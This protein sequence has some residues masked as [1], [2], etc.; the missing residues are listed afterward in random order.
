MR[1]HGSSGCVL[2]GAFAKQHCARPAL[3]FTNS[4]SLALQEVL[5]VLQQLQHE[6]KPLQVDGTR[7]H[8]R[9]IATVSTATTQSRLHF[10]ASLISTGVD[11]KV[12]CAASLGNVPINPSNFNFSF[13]A[14]CGSFVQQNLQRGGATAWSLAASKSEA[15][16]LDAWQ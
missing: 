4:L 7:P 11:C 3:S 5:Q 16:P 10:V 2:A 13:E 1:R 12:C 9:Y 14:F 8:C 15:L 6:A